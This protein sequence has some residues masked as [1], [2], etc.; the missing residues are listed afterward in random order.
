MYSLD[1]IQYF[2]HLGGVIQ[3]GS[4]GAD[5]FTQIGE[6][7]MYRR[8]FWIGIIFITPWIAGGC[9]D[10]WVEEPLTS[11]GM[12]KLL[13]KV[14]LE[15]GVDCAQLQKKFHA[16]DLPLVD[17]PAELSLEYQEH[18]VKTLDGN[19]LRSWYLPASLD[20]GVVLLSYGAVG[21]MPCYLYTARILI[22]N[23]WS[24]VLYD[25]RGFGG[26]TG[27]AD[28]ETLT[29]D[30]DVMVD[31]CLENTG[32]DKV[33][34]MGISLGTIPSIPI[35][36]RR[37]DVVNGVILDSPVVLSMEVTRL[38]S[39]LGKL[40]HQVLDLLPF[41]LLS[42]DAIESMSP[43]VLFFSSGR[44]LLTPPRMVDV[45]FDRTPGP[46]YLV[47]FE[48]IGHARGIFLDT[49]KYAIELE[50]FLVRVWEGREPPATVNLP[51]VN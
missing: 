31:W 51:S 20:R 36:A 24:I 14:V 5:T 28:M 13:N 21:S 1:R 11:A 40:T 7:A 23:G 34:L 18:Y 33:S 38:A 29:A 43:P 22:A 47:R 30:L 12:Y 16:E 50:G 2:S 15:P 35:A 4:F 39:F 37:S 49:E 32:H 45:L 17:T 41:D 26:S 9:V 27:S 25:Y 8:H 48:D 6:A 10:Q 3:L 42:E 44:D 19:S 46:K